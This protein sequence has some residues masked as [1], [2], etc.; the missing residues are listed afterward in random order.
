MNYRLPVSFVLLFLCVWLYHPATHAADVEIS[1]QKG[2][3]IKST[4]SSSEASTSNESSGGSATNASNSSASTSE[5]GLVQRTTASLTSTLSDTVKS[6]ADTAQKATSDVVSQTTGTVDNTTKVVTEAVGNTAGIVSNV[7]DLTQNVTTEAEKVVSG[8]PAD[9]TGA[10]SSGVTNTVN[11]TV[12]TANSAVS[13]T[14]STTTEAVA[15]TVKTVDQTVKAVTE[16]TSEAVTEVVDTTGTVVETVPVIVKDTVNPLPVVSTPVTVPPVGTIPPIITV[17]PISTDPGTGGETPVSGTTP[18]GGQHPAEHNN[19]TGAAVKSPVAERPAGVEAAL[20]LKHPIAKDVTAHSPIASTE[21]PQ[22]QQPIQPEPM[23]LSEQADI[24]VQAVSTI[25]QPATEVSDVDSAT[26]NPSASTEPGTITNMNDSDESNSFL[27]ASSAQQTLQSVSNG[28]SDRGAGDPAPFA[29]SGLPLAQG[30]NGDLIGVLNAG[31]N[32][33]GGQLS[34]SGGNSGSTAPTAM[35]L[36]A[37]A[38]SLFKQ[39]V[40]IYSTK[41]QRGS[42]QWMNAPPAQP[43]QSAPYFNRHLSN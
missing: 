40:W 6:V 35:V 23:P 9:I 2:V 26:T 22:P 5:S 28:T 39:P 24:S 1:L 29:P 32:S 36:E 34:S 19:D 11:D 25:D 42:S 18:G 17:P 8:K 43:P 10:V 12:N 41:S 33:A 38:A 15:E 14:V 27:P 3:S 30:W 4:S 31:S 37:M 21:Q 16:T 13:G 7:N 20:P